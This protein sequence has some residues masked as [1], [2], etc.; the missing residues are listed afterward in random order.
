[1]RGVSVVL[2]VYDGERLLDAAVGAVLAQ[3]LVGP[4]EVLVV[5]DGSR[6]GSRRVAARWAARDDRVRPLPGPG[7]GAPAAINAA[8]RQA[9]YDVVAQLDQ[10]VVPEPTWLGRLVETLESSP[11]VAAVQGHYVADRADGL[12]AR[13]MGLDLAQRYARLG[14]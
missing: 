11:R 14:P 1:M 2:P 12:W 3:D 8:L 9:R 13:V 4:L 7:R 10:D 5:D 6:D